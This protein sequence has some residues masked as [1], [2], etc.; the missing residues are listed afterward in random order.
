[1]DSSKGSGTLKKVV[2]IIYNIA[3]GDGQVL[4]LDI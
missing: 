2:Q 3:L 4:D 1:M